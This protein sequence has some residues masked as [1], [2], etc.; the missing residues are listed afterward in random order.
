MWLATCCVAINT[1]GLVNTAGVA[2]NTRRSAQH[3]L[4]VAVNT[5]GLVNTA[6]A[7]QGFIGVYV[8]GYLLQTFH[9]WSSVFH[10]TA[11]VSFIGAVVYLTFASG[12]RVI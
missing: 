8:A 5:V 4:C 6:G 2:I 7:V 11:V 3:G 1:V 12:E 9:T 10:S